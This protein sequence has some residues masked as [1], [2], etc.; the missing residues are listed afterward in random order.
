[1]QRIDPASVQW[2][3]P[4]P[5]AI[6]W[7]DAPK[8]QAR[9]PALS[10]GERFTRG[11]VDPIDGGAQLLTNMLPRGVV[12]AGNHLN[13]WIADK[14]GLVARLPEGGVDQ[15]VREAEAKYQ[16]RRKSNGDTGFDWMRLGGNIA[17]PANM[18]LA[19]AMPAAAATTAARVGI[20]ALGGAASS[21]LQPV[22]S[23]DF[24]SEKLKQ[25]GV[26][27]IGGGLVPAVAAG[28]GR[29][30]SPKASTN[31][32][33]QLLR[34]EGVRPTLGQ[35]AGGTI[36][37][38]EERAMSLPFVGDSIASARR[39]AENEMNAAVANRA[40]APIK[41][42][43][44]EGVAGREA[45]S[46]VKTALGD[47]YDDLLP[48]LTA[49]ADQ[50]FMTEVGSLRKMVSTGS[51]D[52]RAAASFDRILKADVL[53]KFK[54]Q[55]AM[56]GQTLKQ[57]ESDL[58]AQI[59]RLGQSTDADQRLVGDALK[60]VQSSIRSMLQ[61]SNPQQAETLSKINQGY[62]NFKRME[63]A[64]SYVGAEDGAFSSANLQSA[65]KALDRSKDKGGFARGDA[66]M[67][68]LSDASK[69]VLGNRV[70][71]SGTADRLMLIGTG[72]AAALDPFLT[73]SAIGAGALAYTN[74]V[75]RLLSA[76]LANRPQAAKPIAG[77]LNQAS[78]MLSPAGGLLSLQYS[79]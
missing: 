20:G 23:G 40:L 58:S 26:G 11:L 53:G 57:V 55:G 6:Q 30:I 25:M 22:S 46:Y 71:N 28:I 12:N 61:R 3:A 66:L 59:S 49:K 67:Q 68:D 5:S 65:V 78:P 47:A 62:A 29:V 14:T 45:V 36:N 42:K 77:L 37:K 35:T 1:M 7:D 15:Q 39:R 8:A 33:V 24:T 21:A 74:P 13:N 32:A 73:G 4:D 41:Q 70:P 17:S 9:L 43:L 72:G 27:A 18:A 10:R 19:A 52:P 2:D 76:S 44:P 31:E 79:E 38:I 54:G 60:E 16:D 51:I 50:Q 69:S 75:Q 64:A 48:K 63:R 56:T 34:S